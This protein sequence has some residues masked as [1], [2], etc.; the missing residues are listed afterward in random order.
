MAEANATVKAVL[1]H[2]LQNGGGSSKVVEEW[3]QGTEW[4]RVWSDG[5]IEQGG[6]L[7]S[8]SAISNKTI[9]L[10]KEM[11][12]ADYSLTITANTSGGW[13]ARSYMGYQEKTAISFGLKC[14]IYNNDGN[15]FRGY[16][17]IAAGY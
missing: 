10:P 6:S 15:W 13:A 1:N 5:F 7:E 8:S 16:S 17:W 9:S 4:Y 12:N 3:H 11:P 2:L 14:D